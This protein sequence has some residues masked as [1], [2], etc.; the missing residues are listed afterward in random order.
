DWVLVP[1][2]IGRF[3]PDL[4]SERDRGDNDEYSDDEQG[5]HRP[6]PWHAKVR[7]AG[8]T[9]EADRLA[10]PSGQLS[11]CWGGARR[12]ADPRDRGVRGT[13]GPS[14]AA[15]GRAL[16]RVGARSAWPRAVR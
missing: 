8:A 1:G 5:Q 7:G 3:G 4:L 12:A 11:S 16:H 2:E 10:R 15:V 14:D 13:V 9:P 6:R